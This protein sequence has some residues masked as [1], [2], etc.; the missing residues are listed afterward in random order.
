MRWNWRLWE[1]EGMTRERWRKARDSR[2]WMGECDGG[3][4][5]R[6]E[7]GKGFIVR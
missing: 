2:L 3:K 7:D 5:E 4:M 6:V 1:C